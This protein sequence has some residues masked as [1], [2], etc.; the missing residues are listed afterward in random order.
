MNTT[1]YRAKMGGEIVD[2][3]IPLNE[4]VVTFYRPPVA[5]GEEPSKHQI[6]YATFLQLYEPGS[7]PVAP[8]LPTLPAANVSGIPTMRTQ[9]P[10]PGSPIQLPT[11]VPEWLEDLFTAQTAQLQRIADALDRAIPILKPAIPLGPAT[12]GAQKA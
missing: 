2:A 1:K 11:E 8:T 4:S 10:I 7:T 3:E 5:E 9:G 12:G 6:M